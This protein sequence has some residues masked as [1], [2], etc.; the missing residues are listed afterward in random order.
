MDAAAAW[1]KVAASGDIADSKCR[2]ENYHWHGGGDK[3]RTSTRLFVACEGER[4]AGVAQP[5]VDFHQMGHLWNDDNSGQVAV[6]RELS[7]VPWKD[8]WPPM[9]ARDGASRSLLLRILATFQSGERGLTYYDEMVHHHHHQE[10][11]GNAE[12]ID[13]NLERKAGDENYWNCYCLCK[14]FQGL[15]QEGAPTRCVES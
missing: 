4:G 1:K 7:S 14:R 5:D 11:K 2:V 3:Y 6:G 9:G 13:E 10:G 15:D 8:T 12:H